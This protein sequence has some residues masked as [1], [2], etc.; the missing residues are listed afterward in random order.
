MATIVQLSDV[1]YL[2][3]DAVTV[4]RCEE[5]QWRVWFQDHA[6]ALVLTPEETAVLA[7]Y[8]RNHTERATF[9][10]WS[11]GRPEVSYET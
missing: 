7:L 1:T 10:A 8:L 2:N 9:H 6:H 3:L 5:G 4:L 11:R